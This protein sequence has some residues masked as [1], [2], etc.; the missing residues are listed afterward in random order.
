MKRLWQ[1]FR[2]DRSGTAL[3]EM[4]FV[5]PIFL[6][7]TLA[8]FE[9]AFIFFYAFVLESA[10]YSVTRF[11]K[12]QTDPSAVVQEV[13]DQIG[14]L[15]L[16]LMDPRQ[17]IITTELNVN[18]AQ[19]WENAPPEACEDP[20]TGR[21]S[22]T[23]NCRNTGGCPGTNPIDVNG[24]GKCDIGPPDLELG[25]PGAIISYVAFYKKPLFTPGLGNFTLRKGGGIF[26]S[27]QNGSP[28]DAW[29]LISSATVTRNEPGGP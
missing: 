24:N 28:D 27:N 26:N 8:I 21:A 15:S 19:E 1:R 18:F 22:A 7:M 2:K 5:L 3:V 6:F 16:G 9:L 13:R 20:I 10:M 25:V 12:I 23:E 29:H 14:K 11:A 17:V 4:A